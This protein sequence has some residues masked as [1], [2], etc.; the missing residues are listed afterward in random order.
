MLSRG[1]NVCLCFVSQVTD[2]MEDLKRQYDEK[3]AQKEDLRKKAELTELRLDRAGKLVSG[4]AGERERWEASVK[5]LSIFTTP[6]YLPVQVSGF[7]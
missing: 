1:Q 4:L 2:R 3:L 5:V 6:A 7:R